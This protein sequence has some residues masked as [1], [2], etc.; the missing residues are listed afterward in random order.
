MA[1]TDVI[2]GELQ[3]LRSQVAALTSPTGISIDESQSREKQIFLTYSGN[4]RHDKFILD[5]LDH[6]HPVEEVTMF[7][8]PTIHSHPA[9]VLRKIGASENKI[10]RSEVVRKAYRDKRF[11][12][13]EILSRSSVCGLIRCCPNR[14][15]IS[16]GPEV[17][18]EDVRE[19]LN[20]LIDLV[21]EDGCYQLVLTEAIPSFLFGLF[22][23]DEP[24]N[25]KH[26]SLFGGTTSE[27]KRWSPSALVMTDP[28][29]YHFLNN[30]FAKWAMTHP[31]STT[32]AED[33]ASE[34]KKIRTHFDN[35]G[36]ITTP[37]FKGIR[38]SKKVRNI[39]R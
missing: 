25:A 36:P 23:V 26:Y 34:L 8:R 19:H 37:D 2:L 3:A 35:S 14:G 21:S 7:Y 11:H 6:E 16:Y 4:N 15:F 39:I 1:N 18:E 5:L 32:C 17:G 31:S 24:A 10:R 20:Y 13:T 28:S 30:S 9:S 22:R 33:T 27:Q 12:Y 29:V 38:D